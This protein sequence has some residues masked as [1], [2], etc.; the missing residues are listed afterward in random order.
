MRIVSHLR[1]NWIK[2]CFEVL[3]VTIGVLFAVF[4]NNWNENRKN[5]QTELSI[6]EELVQ[7]LQ[8][9]LGTLQCNID[10][11]TKAKESCKII[12]S[13][14]E[15]NGEYTDSLA[16]H[17]AAT[18]YYTVSFSKR[19][20][21]E[22]LKTMGF[23]TISNEDLRIRLID[24]Y[25]Q[26]F[27]I[28]RVN[29]EIL[30]SE[31]QNLKRNFNQDHFKQFLIFDVDHVQ[32]LYAGQMIPIDFS[33]LKHNVQYSYHLNSLHASHSFVLLQMNYTIDIINSILDELN[34]E[35]HDLK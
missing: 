13:I 22:S 24:L 33:S 19:G 8:S 27:R 31:I 28:V 6:L 29:Q 10:K 15:E 25:E 4:I 3:V 23:E 16:K 26:W 12:L 21:Y 34:N 5:K 30:T 11:H 18:H 35:I 2:Y 32:N 9:D 7:E 17:F 20:A 14:L 1:E